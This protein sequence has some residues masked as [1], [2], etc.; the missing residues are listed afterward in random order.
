M[1]RCAATGKHGRH[2]GYKRGVAP[3]NRVLSL[4]HQTII[5]LSPEVVTEGRRLVLFGFRSDGNEALRP[6]ATN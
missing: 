1:G 3:S 4:A 5:Q 6:T 2:Q